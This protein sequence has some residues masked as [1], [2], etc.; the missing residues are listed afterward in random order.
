MDT[1]F[2]SVTSIRLQHGAIPQAHS[3]KLPDRFLKQ[4]CTE[5]RKVPK[6]LQDKDITVWPIRQLRMRTKYLILCQE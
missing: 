6:S 1:E 5:P 4:I 3:M 2:S